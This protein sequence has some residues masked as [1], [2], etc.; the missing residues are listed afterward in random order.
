ML[1]T[2]KVTPDHLAVIRRALTSGAEESRMEESP[3]D[4]GDESDS[5]DGPSR[6]H[7]DDSA[8]AVRR[9]TK[10]GCKTAGAVTHSDWGIE[11]IA[12]SDECT[13]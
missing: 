11:D 1:S 2:C 4:S 12:Q 9:Q 10:R 13:S 3:M 8:C 5:S 6:G 7:M